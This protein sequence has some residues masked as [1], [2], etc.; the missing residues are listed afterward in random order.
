MWKNGSKG[1]R[2]VCVSVEWGGGVIIN[3]ISSFIFLFLF[4]FLL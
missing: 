3:I 1:M 2:L 4:H